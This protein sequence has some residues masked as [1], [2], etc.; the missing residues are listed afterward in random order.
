[1]I[2]GQVM[3]PN[4]GDYGIPVMRAIFF[5]TKCEFC[6]KYSRVYLS[7]LYQIL[8]QICSAA[9]I[10]G[11]FIFSGGTMMSLILASLCG[12]V[13]AVVFSAY[14]SRIKLKGTP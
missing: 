12:V 8:V 14:L 6:K 11:V 2:K 5:Y 1:M 3:C 7:Y 13:F 10:W 4:C 9:I